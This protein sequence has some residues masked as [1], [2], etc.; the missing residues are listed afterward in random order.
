MLKMRNDSRLSNAHFE[1]LEDKSWCSPR[2]VIVVVA[3][4]DANADGG[5]ANQMA[6]DLCIKDVVLHYTPTRLSLLNCVRSAD[7]VVDKA[8]SLKSGDAQMAF[9]PNS[10]GLVVRSQPF[11]GTHVHCRDAFPTRIDQRVRDRLHTVIIPT[12]V[13]TEFANVPCWTAGGQDCAAG[14]KPLQ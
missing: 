8:S 5:Y 1:H 9:R 14:H 2:M 12:Q 13:D 10:I 3:R 11:Q 4:N 7:C 6:H